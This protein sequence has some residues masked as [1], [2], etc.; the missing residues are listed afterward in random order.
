MIP[1]PLVTI[2]TPM[3]NARQWAP[4]LV[5]VT[6]R[7]TLTDYEHL[8]VDDASDDDGALVLRRLIAADARYHL[9]EMPTNSGPAAARNMAIR[10]ARGRFLAFLDADDVWLPT[11]LERQVHWMLETGCAFSYHDYRHMSHDGGLVGDV[12]VAPDV[13]GF[14]AL[15]T[16]KG[17]GCLAVM[18]DRQQI[19]DFLFPELD[20]TLPEDFLAWLKIIE[21]GIQGHRL[22]EDLA[23]YRR[24]EKSRSSNKIR[25]A[26][27]MWTIYARIERLSFTRAAWW[28]LRYALAA[29]SLHRRA[30][31]RHAWNPD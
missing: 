8:I 12:V 16:R 19:P 18:I 7:Q 27:A 3:H 15:H 1:T 2:I 4:G 23:R 22:P 11:K 14:K 5:A 26:A 13:L 25:A 10:R 29:H 6:Q 31:P 9:L 28:W 24:S 20:R 21:T 17:V 30:V